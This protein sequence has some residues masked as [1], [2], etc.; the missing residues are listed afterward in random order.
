ML[1]QRLTTVAVSL[2][3]KTVKFLFV[4]AEVTR[5]RLF[6][7]RH[8]QLSRPLF[9]CCFVVQFPP[10]SQPQ[11]PPNSTSWPW[12]LLFIFWP[13]QNRV[14]KRVKRCQKVTSGLFNC[15]P[16]SAEWS[17]PRVA[18]GGIFWFPVP[19]K[20]YHRI[21]HGKKWAAPIP[22]LPFAPWLL[23]CSICAGP[24]KV[25]RPVLL[26]A[27][28]HHSS[29]VTYLQVSGIMLKTGPIFL[30]PFWSG[31]GWILDALLTTYASWPKMTVRCSSPVG[32][33]RNQ[34][35]GIARQKWETRSPT[36]RAGK[37]I[38]DNS[39]QKLAGLLW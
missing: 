2:V 17:L 16:V 28:T 20:A 5:L 3:K 26:G 25:G 39:C 18:A 11:H 14:T 31:N 38:G 24:F 22:R 9:L 35:V 29:P 8:S 10:S 12:Y 32:L 15:P 23:C 27:V 13:F 7:I 21:D 33:S 4:A 30:A 6:L 37:I 1:Y 36:N 34:A 19:F